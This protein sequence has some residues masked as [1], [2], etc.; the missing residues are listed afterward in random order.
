MLQNNPNLAKID[1][2]KKFG[3]ILSICFQDIE[4][5]R[6]SD[7]IKGRESVINEPKITVNILNLDL[8]NVN[9]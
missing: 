7:T 5:K 4:Q 3:P 9:V 8:I 2:Y 1:V 6:N